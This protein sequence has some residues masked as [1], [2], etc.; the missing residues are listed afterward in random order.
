[1]SVSK[2]VFV[3][4]ALV[5]VSHGA[6]AAGGSDPRGGNSPAGGHGDVRKP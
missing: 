3:L 6:L 4:A 5:S 1:M 2:W